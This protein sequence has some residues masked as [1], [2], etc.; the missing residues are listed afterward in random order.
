MPMRSNGWYYHNMICY[1]IENDIIKLDNIK[2][3]IKSSL[4]LPKNYYNK[5]IAFCYNNIEN[6]NKLAI[7]SMIGNFKPNINKRETWFSKS[8]SESSC[9]A[10]NT[11]VN[12]QGCFIDVKT[13]NDK[14]YYHTFKKS[15][16]TNL[17]TESPIYNQILQQEQIELHKLGQLIK[18]RSGVIL[19]YN[20]DAINC[21]FPENKFPFELVEDIQLNGHYWNKSNKVYKYKIEYN[22][23]RLKTSKMQQTHRLD[24]FNDMK[25]YQWNVITD[26]TARPRT[27]KEVNRP[28]NLNFRSLNENYNRHRILNYY[29]EYLVSR[30]RFNFN[31]L[32]KDDKHVINNYYYEYLNKFNILRDTIIKSNQSYFITGPGGSGKTTL[33]K[34]LQDV[35]TKQDKKY[36]TLCPTNLAALLVGGMTIHRF[37]AKLKKQA[38]VQTLDLD[39]IF[40]DE[41]SMLGEVFYKFLMMIKK[42]RPNIKFIISGDHNQLKPIN[43]RISPKTDYANS[44]CLFELADY[45]KVQLTI[46]RRAN[47]K[48]YNLIKFDN[49][50]NVKPSDF[51]ETNEYKNNIHI[52][53]TNNKRMEINHI[54]MKELYKKKY[55][56]GLE[57]EGLSYDDRSQAVILNKGVPIISKVNN[58]DIGIFNNQRFKIV[59]YDAF[60]ITIKDDF[61]NLIKINIPDFQK[62]F[63]VAYATTTHSA[64]GMS[65]GKPY[66]I[67]EW[68]RMDQ[69]LLYVSLSRSRAYEY[70]NVM[71]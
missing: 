2:Y 66:T 53:F 17:E 45:N 47:A 34:Q 67:H 29:H 11:F 62:F 42:I 51:T 16:S 64:Q 26:E 61:E 10:Y 28:I 68:D 20:T 48:L 44:P 7:N 36:V 43:D 39:Y 25:S 6:Y 3:V 8:F 59:K 70:I 1:C 37:A 15:Y 71:K 27:I 22:K 52:C 14:K 41:V 13:I 33:L 65:I 19:D 32:S 31:D 12:H 38:Q 24:T 4:S 60:T 63:L 50:P 21:S 49:I 5:F 30:P 58:E 56:K 57:I 23:E 55:R 46:C 35:I 54:K 69:R 9:E 18:A 40:V